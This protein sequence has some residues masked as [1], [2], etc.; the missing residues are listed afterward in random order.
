VH[1]VLLGKRERKAP[2][3]KFRSGWEENITGYLKEV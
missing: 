2:F 1:G 3:V